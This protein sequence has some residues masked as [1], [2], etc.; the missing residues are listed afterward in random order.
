LARRREQVALLSRTLKREAH[1]LMREPEVLPSHMHNMLYLDEGE[2]SSAGALL[3][4]PR[5]GS[6]RTAV[7]NGLTC[8]RP[9]QPCESLAA[10]GGVP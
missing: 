7:T 1:I 2:E 6:R 4:W 10:I 9:S 5:G 8:M 3:A